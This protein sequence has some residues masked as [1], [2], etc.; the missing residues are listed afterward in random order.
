MVGKEVFQALVER[1]DLAQVS[2]E[3]VFGQLDLQNM[4]AEIEAVIKKSGLIT[5]AQVRDR[6]QTSRRY[7]LAVLEAMDRQGITSREGDLR[8]LRNK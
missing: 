8:K 4:M 2:A 5:L 7:A 3:V 1:G 6:F